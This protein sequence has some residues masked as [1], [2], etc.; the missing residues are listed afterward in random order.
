MPQR[1]T[2]EAPARRFELQTDKGG[3]FW[4]VRLEEEDFL[5]IRS[6]DIGKGAT[7][8]KKPFATADA[9]TK[10]M[11]RLIREKLKKGYVAV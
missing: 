10:E 6:G 9:A 8:Q 4:E 3:K 5:H 2:T 7:V 1:N 11:E